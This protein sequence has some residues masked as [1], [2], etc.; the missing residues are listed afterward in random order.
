MKGMHQIVYDML[1]EESKVNTDKL[2]AYDD[3][4]YSCATAQEELELIRKILKEVFNF[5]DEQSA[6]AE[7]GV[8]KDGKDSKGKKR[9]KVK[10]D[11][12]GDSEGQGEGQGEEPGEVGEGEEEGK[13]GGSIRWEDIIPDDHN[14]IIESH[15]DLS[16]NYDGHAIQEGFFVHPEPD[17]RI[18]EE[19]VKRGVVIQNVTSLANKVRKLLQVKS[20]KRWQHNEVKGK[21][22]SRSLHNIVTPQGDDY[23]IFKTKTSA[24][25]LDASVSLL[26][27][28]SGSMGGEK[29]THAVN[30]AYNMYCSLS[31][32]RIST[33]IIGFQSHS[34]D[35]FYIFKAFDEKLPESRLALR[36][37]NVGPGSSNEDA[38]AL[39]FAANRLVRRKTTGK[40]L[41]V[42]SDGQPAG[43]TKD[44]MSNAY[45]VAKMIES[46]NIDLIGIGILD[47]S[48]SRIYKKYVVIK[49]SSQLEDALMKII[50]TRLD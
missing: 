1:P 25:S 9:A 5:T 6:S 3:E 11:K 50:Q 2:G 44:S 15:S 7:D 47:D 8:G 4:L 16:I 29:W 33:E 10:A 48:V 31:K 36:F 32:L 35:V 38:A 40:H 19:E 24:I 26:I 22:S 27:D 49:K 30:A 41:I 39:M 43:Y 13:V 18:P 23:K 12:S 45:R 17:I 14:R 34:T 37:Q 46:T 20:Q 21:I 28:M 42:F